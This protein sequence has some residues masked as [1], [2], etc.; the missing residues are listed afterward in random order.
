MLTCTLLYFLKPNFTTTVGSHSENSIVLKG[1]GISEH[2]CSV[3]NRSGE[4]TIEKSKDNTGRVVV[5]GSQLEGKKQLKHNDWVLLGRAYAL[6]VGIPHQDDGAEEAPAEVKEMVAQLAPEESDAYSELRFY[7]EEMVSKMGQDRIQEFFDV[8]KEA[9]PLVDEAN[10]ITRHVSSQENLKFEV[11]FVWDIYNCK[12]SEILLIRVLKFEDHA[13]SRVLYYWTYTHFKARLV[14]M[15]DAYH[16]FTASGAIPDPL[17]NP[18]LEPDFNAI[19]QRRQSERHEERI[20]AHGVLLALSERDH[21]DREAASS[22][23]ALSGNLVSALALR[24]LK[25]AV[26]V[27]RVSPALSRL[28][29]ATVA[30]NA[31][32]KR[33]AKPAGAKPA[34]GPRLPAA[35]PQRAA[36]R[37][38]SVEPTD[39]RAEAPELAELRAATAEAEAE[40]ARYRQEAAELEQKLAAKAVEEDK[41]LAQLRE[42]PARPLLR[43]TPA[44]VQPPLGG[45]VLQQSLAQPLMRDG[46]LLSGR[47]SPRMVGMRDIS[48]VQSGSFVS[49]RTNSPL[50]VPDFREIRRPSAPDLTIRTSATDL[51]AGFSERVVRGIHSSVRSLSP[52]PVRGY[53]PGEWTEVIL[54]APGHAPDRQTSRPRGSQIRQLSAPARRVM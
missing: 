43:A 32:V 34:P 36:K 23:A 49:V 2:L 5:N 30:R 39:A 17:D 48:R 9:C 16:A 29:K 46:P 11:E 3:E 8:L 6:R 40:A 45:S 25:K 12:A 28:T 51:S 1:L 10:E 50:V 7:V 31:A 24:K 52:P 37:A 15:R 35:S 4:L 22:A 41:L 33:G 27:A 26:N 47:A 38:A 18:W 14:L 21:P 19:K 13:T 53:V 44:P 42:R 20:A 54:H